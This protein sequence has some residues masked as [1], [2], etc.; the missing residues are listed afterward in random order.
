MTQDIKSYAK[1]V[2]INVDFL[3]NRGRMT[4]YDYPLYATFVEGQEHVKYKNDE[5]LSSKFTLS[6]SN[7]DIDNNISP[8][9][10]SFQKMTHSLIDIEKVDLENLG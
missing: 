3:I 4:N 6:Q 7:F 5:R 1:S 9:P 2:E 10:I 8:L